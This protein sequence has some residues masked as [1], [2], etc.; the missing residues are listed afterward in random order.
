[1]IRPLVL[2]F[3]GLGAGT[4]PA[5]RPRLIVVI[6]VDQ[7][8]PD[9]LE[10]YR[11]QLKG[12]FAMLLRTG[13]SFTDAYQ[14]HAVTET[15]P[16]HSTIL[17]GRWPVHTGITRN[18]AGVQD[19]A[20]PLI[21]V[22]GPGAS[23]M[24]FRGTEFFDWLKA[25]EPGARALSI[26]GKDRGAILP[27]GRAKERVYW[28]FGGFFTTSRYYADS[29][30]T[31]VRVF[32]GQRIPF[33]AAGTLWTLFLP[34]REYSEPDSV[35]YENQGR[36]VVFPHRLP[37][38]SGEAALAFVA[39]PTMDSLTLAFAL[40]GVRALQL[41][42]RGA[43]DLLAVSLSTT[44]YVGHAYG[45][46]SREIHDQVVRLDRYLG[47]FLE[48]LFVRY[49]RNNVLVVLTADHGVTPFPER[50]RTMGH[51]GAV[52]VIP[53]T[54]I[55]GVNA[56]LD[57]RAGGGDWV[58]LE[59]GMLLVPDRA[60]LVAQGVNVDSVVADVATRLRALPGVARVDRP[61]D[62]APKDTADPVL[63][64]W[65]HH[66]PP[67][68]GVELVATLKPYSIWS[69]A[70]GFIAMHGQPTELD[71]HVPLILWG[72]GVRRG[73]YAGRVST[74]DIAPTLARLLELTP[75]EPL[76][77]RVLTEALGAQN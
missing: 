27:I 21:G 56:A 30:P 1:M 69:P 23:P 17:S 58:Q 8:R 37:T 29:L 54:I 76:D 67:D 61:A 46:D 60:K 20:A 14:D 42:G 9:Y 66:L 71:S 4:A 51:P 7:L 24:R 28:Y 18:L 52:R 26:S 32:N 38:D 6:T 16:G 13:A 31:W 57:Q 44:D 73:V 39:T 47:W 50:S 25:A 41:G 43:T 48:Q 19:P 75:A 10:R 64:R 49:G 36:D 22:N 34:E 5:P 15:A 63:R 2:L 70:N 59:S 72:P 45:P 65:I 3:A 35:A 77:G 55:Q 12:G 53:D 74:V 68:G 11:P 40:E 62:L 33:R